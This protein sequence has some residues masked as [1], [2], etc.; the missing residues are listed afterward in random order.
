MTWGLEDRLLLS[1]CKKEIRR[2]VQNNLSGML[3]HIDWNVFLEKA[4]RESISSLVFRRLP[5][6]VAGDTIIPTRITEELKKDYYAVAGR[7]C[8]I[9]EELGRVLDALDNAGLSAMVLKGA[10]LCETVYGNP[11]LRSMSDV[12]LL[13]RKKDVYA[14]DCTLRSIGY[15]SSDIQAIDPSVAPGDCLTSL[16]YRSSSRNSPC[17]HVHW[18]FVNSTIPNSALISH[19]DMK[20][21]WH[22]AQTARIAGRQTLAMAPHH[23]FIHLAE[24]SLRV[25]HSLSKLSF[26]CD[27][28]EAAGFYGESVDWDLLIRESKRFKLHCLVYIPLYFAVEFLDARIP[29]DI[30]LRLRPKRF[31]LHE[32]IFIQLISKNHRFP[33]L[34]YLLHLSINEGLCKKVRFVLR[35]LFPPPRLIAHRCGIHQNNIGCVFYL[36][37]ITDVLLAVAAATRKIVCIRHHCAQTNVE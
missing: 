10:A 13:I 36:R 26:L 16:A 5:E 23:L 20:H 25:R 9:L 29:E 17:F 11:A 1:C 27:I 4:R 8:V 22:D 18:H 7:N 19:I 15:F 28:N 3:G 14:A 6:V 32:K 30:I 21:I 24:H 2:E 33:G 12:D 37:R 34:S 31:G 35:T